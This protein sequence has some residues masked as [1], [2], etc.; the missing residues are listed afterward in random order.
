[1]SS[2]GVPPDTGQPQEVRVAVG[3][4]VVVPTQPEEVGY[5]LR[6]AEFDILC[7]G[8]N[9]N[10]DER[11]RDVCI[12]VCATALMSLFALFATA[13]WARI[14]TSK[15]WVAL[16]LSV[17]LLVIFVSSFVVSL[18]LHSRVKRQALSSGYSRLKTRIENYFERR[19]S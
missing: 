1:M 16:T 10:K 3:G 18:I 15:A 6:R 5:P 2:S 19:T 12:G 17:V 14:L 11:W 9:A 7:E 13:D 4:T 8:E